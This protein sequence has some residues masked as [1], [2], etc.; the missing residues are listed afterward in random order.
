MNRSDLT[1]LG[2]LISGSGRTMLNLHECI[3]RGELPAEIAIVISTKPEVAGVRR[4]KEAGLPVE[5]ASP[6]KTSGPDFHR[7]IT[8]LLNEADVDLVCMAGFLSLW[9]IPADYAGRVLNIHPALL[10]DF[11]GKGFFGL[12]VHRAV[13]EAAATESGCTVHLAD[14]QYDHGPILLQRKVP[15]IP[16]DT[17]ESLAARVFEQEIIAY[18]EAIR[19]FFANPSGLSSSECRKGGQS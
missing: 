15:V 8:D 19:Q 7:R 18:P 3:L 16:G 14:N 11:G 5:I 13:L 9:K 2:I 4:A 17:P 6:A 10:P 12:N 1:K